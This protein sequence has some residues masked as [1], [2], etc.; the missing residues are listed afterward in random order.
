MRGQ[1]CNHHLGV[2]A[3]SGLTVAAQESLV[4]IDKKLP[5]ETAALFGCAVMTGVGA[6]FNTAQ[7]RAGTSVAVFGLGGVGLSAI[8]GA[9]AAG[10]F[11]IIAIDVL[12]DKLQLAVEIG[13]THA[14]NAR[15]SDA[16][17]AIRDLTNG[18]AENVFESVG[19]ATVLLQAYNSTARGGTTI[20]LGLPAP[21]KMLAIPAVSLVAEERIIKGSYMGSAVPRRDIP[22]FI[23][24]FQAGLL[25]VDKLHTHT[26]KLE[27]INHGFDRLDRAEAV[28]Q[29]II[30]D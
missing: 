30:L 18:G 3:F 4:K 7:V 20:T 15:K 12:P 9:R 10:A 5:L 17:G 29:I 16:V 22:K 11:P 23:Q 19:S 2:S 26:L 27:D 21:D 1:I 24:M 28:R 8:M 6:V 14:I 13:A 25:P